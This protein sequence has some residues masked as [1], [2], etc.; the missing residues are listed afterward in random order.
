LEICLKL[1]IPAVTVYAF[2]ID[3]FKR[4]QDEVDALMGLAKVKL[5]ELAGHGYVHP[6]IELPHGPWADNRDLLQQYGVRIRFVGRRDML[7]RDVLEAVDRMEAMTAGN[8]KYVLILIPNGREGKMDQEA[9]LMNSG[10]L[11]VCSPYTARDETTTAIRNSVQE[12]YDGSL[13]LRYVSLSLSLCLAF[14][15]FL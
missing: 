9:W 5:S 4:T 13:P 10:V 7:P 14:N 8:K 11:N 12:V 2:S 3:N 15:Q 1:K 6:P